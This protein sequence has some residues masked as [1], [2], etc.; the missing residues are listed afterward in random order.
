[1]SCCILTNMKITAVETF[2]V[3]EDL[4]K[5]DQ[6]AYSQAWFNDRTIL[7]L[8]V[9]TDSGLEGWGEAFGPALIHKQTIEQIYG[10]MILGRD[11]FDTEVIWMELYN[12]LRD[13]GQKGLSIEALSAVD[14]ALW[15]IKGKHADLPVYK[16]MGGSPRDKVMPY[17]TGLYRRRGDD[18]EAI[19]E[20]I[21][22]EARGHA[23][24]GYRGMKIKTGF[25]VEYDVA[26]VRAVRKAVGPDIV[27]MVDA[28][29]AYNASTAIRV[30]RKLEEFD[31]T[32]FEEPVPPED[33]D[34]YREVK[35][36]INI[37]VAGGEAEFTRFGFTRLLGARAVD[38]AQPDCTVTGGIS[39]YMKIVS[40][41]TIHNIQC[42]PHVWGSAVA[43]KTGLHCCFALPDFPPSLAPSPA[44]LEH[45]RTENVFREKL[46]L[47]PMVMG[48]DG[49]VSA[50]SEPG[51]GLQIDMNLVDSYRIA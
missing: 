6:F 18:T 32:W 38:V 27:L 19:I 39:E 29:H 31:I 45:D 30:G 48:P 20:D 46:D 13:H 12:K 1:M 43:L 21:V 33:L 49:T 9:T 24:A 17:A 22:A 4:G 44:L 26:L 2:V 47:N 16:L 10:P 5:D 41:A 35:G 7:L 28:N 15:D 23:A 36:G 37:P 8:K 11:P 3:R 14:I 50:P 42:Y 40:L 34:G 51:L 25:G